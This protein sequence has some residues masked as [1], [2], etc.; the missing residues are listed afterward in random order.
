MAGTVQECRLFCL[1]IFE[2]ID[3]LL[4]ENDTSEDLGQLKMSEAKA[5]VSLKTQINVIKTTS[6][7]LCMKRSSVY[8]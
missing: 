7:F 1:I 8:I 6:Y 5:E 3:L 4:L 2:A